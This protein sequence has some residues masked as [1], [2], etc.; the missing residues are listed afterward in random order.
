M[1]DYNIMYLPQMSLRQAQIFLAASVLLIVAAFG[2]AYASMNYTQHYA[3]LQALVTGLS[4][5]AGILFSNGILN[6]SNKGHLKKLIGLVLL[7]VISTLLFIALSPIS[8]SVIEMQY[9]LNIIGLSLAI[10]F[11]F[12]LVSL[13]YTILVQVFGGKRLTDLEEVV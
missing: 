12:S 13:L 10:F 4:V 1:M 6:I 8:G 7:L 2:T 9:R 3:I 11:E 5:G